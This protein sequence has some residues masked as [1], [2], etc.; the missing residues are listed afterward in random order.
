MKHKPLN[1]DLKTLGSEI[2][3]LLQPHLKPLSPLTSSAGFHKGYI[4]VA[5]CCQVCS[6]FKDVVLAFTSRFLFSCSNVWVFLFTQVPGHISA[7][8]GRKLSLTRPCLLKQPYHIFVVSPSHFHSLRSV[9]SYLEFFFSCLFAHLSP[10]K[11]KI[12]QGLVWLILLLNPQSLDQC[13]TPRRSSV[14]IS[15]MNQ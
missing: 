8:W 11:E 15:W 9:H 14:Y 6:C 5:F 12:M 7:L 4:S 2:W 3:L 1:S 10:D 13:W